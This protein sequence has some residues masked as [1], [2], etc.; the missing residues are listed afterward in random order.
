MP[1]TT[2][3]VK[4]FNNIA[5]LNQ[6][7]RDLGNGTH[8]DSVVDEG[9]LSAKIISSEFSNANLSTLRG[10]VNTYLASSSKRFHSISWF[11][12]GIVTITFYAI[13]NEIDE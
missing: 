13:I 4:S 11:G 5:S 3:Q 8:G 9:Q 2:R 6:K 10:A 7:M 12:A 1:D